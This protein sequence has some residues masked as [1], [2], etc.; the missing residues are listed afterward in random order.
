[1]LPDGTAA[2]ERLRFQVQPAG[3]TPGIG[4]PAPRSESLTAT[5]VLEV[6]RI[7]TDP[8]PYA[9]AYTQTVAEAV[10]SGRP[11][12]IFFATPAFCQT[13]FCGPTVELVKG[14][15]R[16]VEDEVAFFN[17][18]PSAPPETY[19][20]RHPPPYAD[21]RRP[22]V[23]A[24]LDYGIPVEPYLFVVDAQGDVFAKFEGIVGGD[25]LRAAIEDVLAGPT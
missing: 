1:M 18:K 23:A 2:R 21:R 20:G 19:T 9:A 22:H 8:N 10:T 7:A 25:E 24:A 15:A 14:V 3:S 17:F 16:E 11:S 4:A 6:R 5:T 13:G 12:L